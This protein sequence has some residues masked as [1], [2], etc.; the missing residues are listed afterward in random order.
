[1][2]AFAEDPV[3][4]WIIP[5]D[6]VYFAPGGAVFDNAMSMWLR[7]GE[8]WCTDD[9]AGVAAW[10]PPGRPDPPPAPT[11]DTPPAPPPPDRV[12]RYGII[13]ALLDEHT[14]GDDHWYLQLIATHPDWQRRGVAGALLE[15][16]FER[17][18]ADALPCYLETE[19]EVN[20]AYYRS[21]GFEV[22]SEFDIPAGGHLHRYSS[23]GRDPADEIG[24]HMWGMLRPPR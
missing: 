17:A 8:V 5:E 21:H 11:T 10:I 16:M 9:A 3:M 4:R 23:W 1:M 24:P 15:S 14:P 2:H 13:G 19:T 12:D 7:L 20:V 6:E 22:V 18:D